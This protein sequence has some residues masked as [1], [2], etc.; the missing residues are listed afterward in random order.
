MKTILENFVS[1]L[2]ANDENRAIAV[3]GSYAKG[4]N[5]PDS[6]VDLLV[7]TKA[8]TRRDVVERERIH[9]EIVYATQ[10][11]AEEYYK[12]NLD[13]FVRFWRHARILYDPEKVLENF[14]MQAQ[15]IEKQGKK[16]LPE[17]KIKHFKFDAEDQLRAIKYLNSKDP[18]TATLMLSNVVFG[19]LEFYFDYKQIWKPAPKQLLEELRKINRD[20]ARKFENCFLCQDMQDKIM[21]ADGLVQDIFE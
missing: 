16:A 19:L 15:E 5:R 7:I 4:L 18:A 9:F 13:N 14:R 12:N 2:Q 20:L 8:S 17:N 21:L 1:E 3:F 6:D 11:D 10:P